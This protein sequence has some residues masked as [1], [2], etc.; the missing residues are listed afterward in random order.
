[1]PCP[2]LRSTS[3]LWTSGEGDGGV[4]V[5]TPRTAAPEP[6]PAAPLASAGSRGGDYLSALL[7]R[8]KLGLQYGGGESSMGLGRLL[9]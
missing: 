5:P 9:L 4:P 8:V 7:G 6:S 3:A 1:M 2:L